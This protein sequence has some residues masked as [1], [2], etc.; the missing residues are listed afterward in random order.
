MSASV[1]LPVSVCSK[2]SR[3]LANFGRLTSG[4]RE[5]ELEIHEFSVAPQ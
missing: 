2:V 1:C 4:V 5:G 3:L